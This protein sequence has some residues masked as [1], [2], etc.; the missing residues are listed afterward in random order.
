MSAVIGG[1]VAGYTMALVSTFVFTW[2]LVKAKGPN[3]VERM[4]GEGTPL[5]MAAIPLSLGLQYCW[6]MF[7]LSIGIIYHL[8]DLDS[9]PDFLGSPSGPFLAGT[10]V[11]AVMPL[12]FLLLQWPR[13]WWLWLILQGSF[14]GLFGWAFPIMAS[15]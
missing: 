6:T 1:W 15:R 11:I 13:R 3:F 8:T 10:A 7:G 14:L 12:P 9:T 4:L 2:L 5:G